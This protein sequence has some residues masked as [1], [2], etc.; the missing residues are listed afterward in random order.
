[1]SNND[2]EREP[3]RRPHDALPAGVPVAAAAVGRG[4]IPRR[5]AEEEGAVALD[6]M[7]PPVEVEPPPIGIYG[8][9]GICN[10]FSFLRHYISESPVTAAMKFALL[11]RW[12]MLP[13]YGDESLLSMAHVFAEARYHASDLPNPPLRR[14][15]AVGEALSPMIPHR[16]FY[17]IEN[18]RVSL[19][20]WMK[21]GFIDNIFDV[22]RDYNEVSYG[23]FIRTLPVTRHW[24]EDERPANYL[25]T[26]LDIQNL[27]FPQAL[28][29]CYYF[30]KNLRIPSR[31]LAIGYITNAFCALSKRG[32]V[33]DEFCNKINAAVRDELGVVVNLH[34]GTLN[35]IYKGYMQG[36]NENNAQDVFNRLDEMIPD[37]ALR[38]KLTLMQA[39]GSGLTLFMIIGRALRLYNDF[40][41]SRVNTLTSGELANWT[42]AMRAIDG[43]LYYGFKRDLGVARSTLYKSLG[44]VAHE[45]LMKINGEI[46]LRCFMGLTGNVKNKR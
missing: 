35:A 42:Q 4:A 40:P 28:L 5:A 37:I 9:L 18:S 27:T 22:L 13:P 29:Y 20:E 44:Y 33:T 14:A 24:N 1:M 15:I 43:N 31:H 41:W 25:P 2:Q 12:P 46:T 3:L 17:T 11:Q 36:V 32:Q 19:V 30:A 7:Q 16:K 45:L 26:L 6:P 23:Q 34:S 38:L 8:D 10:N 21:R 39:S